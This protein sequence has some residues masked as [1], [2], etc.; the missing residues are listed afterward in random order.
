MKRV[1]S[2]IQPSGDIHLGNYLGAIR[3]W[4]LLL[5][6][7]DCIFCIV[8]YHAQTIPYDPQAM[9]RRVMNAAV[10]NMAAGI[11][12]KRCRLFVQSHVKEVTELAW[13]L[14]CVTPLGDLER[15][16]QFKSKTQEHQLGSN[17]GLLAYP[18][19]MAADILLYKAELVPVGDDQIQ[20]LEL[21]REICRKFDSTFG[22]VF[23]E[24]QPL[25]TK[26][27]RVMGIDGKTKMSKSLNN[28][29]G[30]LETEEQVWSKLKV[31]VTDEN[32]KRR[33][34][35]GNPLVCNVFTIHQGFTQDSQ[36]AQIDKE[37]R[38]AGIGCVDCKKILAR[39]LE[40]VMAP[41]R[42]RARHLESP[43]DEVRQILDEGASA[44]REI[45]VRVMDE[46][47]VATGLRDAR[48]Q[49]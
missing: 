8:D 26:T 9:P 13:I 33:T 36:I 3:N 4:V 35:P 47:R 1:F 39:N 48:R 32:R 11:D 49:Q 25:L 27:S 10:A 6:Q 45:A 44:C 16:T 30:L 17:L 40:A 41:M 5:D 24:P 18:V 22:P 29:I 38:S 20:H 23:P 46:V 37:C 28:T 42:E 21:A 15:M 12:P 34:D 14:G 43:P 19:L 31:A 2:G 7:Y